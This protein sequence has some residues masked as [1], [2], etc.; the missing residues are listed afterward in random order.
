MNQWLYHFIAGE[1][2]FICSFYNR[3]SDMETF[4]QIRNPVPIQRN[5][6]AH[7]TPNKAEFHS[8]RNKRHINLRSHHQTEYQVCHVESIAPI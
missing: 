6:M 3:A 7:F 2:R 1:I 8:K 4:R 5:V